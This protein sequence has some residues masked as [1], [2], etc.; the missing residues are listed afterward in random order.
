MS[1]LAVFQIFFQERKLNAEN[2]RS[3]LGVPVSIK[4]LSADGADKEK[5]ACA[6]CSVATQ[7]LS[8]FESLLQLGYTRSCPEKCI[9]FDAIIG[10]WHIL[11]IF[12]W[13]DGDDLTGI[14]CRQIWTM[15]AAKARR[16]LTVP[17]ENCSLYTYLSV[18]GS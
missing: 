8:R 1:D 18:K 12:R 7:N 17:G 16:R 14:S 15:A 9:D 2:H 11:L 4:K 5:G 6:L 10:G 3:P 13:T